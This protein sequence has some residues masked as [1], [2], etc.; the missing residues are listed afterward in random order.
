M[1]RIGWGD[2]HVHEKWKMLRIG[3]GDVHVHEKWKMLR[4]L[5]GDVHVHEKW[6][7][8]RIGWGD[9]HVHE[10]WKMLRI[11]WG[12]VHVHEKWKMLRIRWGDVHVHEK[13]K[14]LRI[15]WGDV[16]VHEKWK[17]LRIGWG[18][19]HVHEKWKMLRIGWGDVHVHEKWKML[20]ILWGDVH[21][22]E[23][24]KMLRIGWGDVHVHEKWKM[25]RIG[26]GDTFFHE[27]WKPLQMGWGDVLMR[28]GR[29]YRNHRQLLEIMQKIFQVVCTVDIPSSGSIV[30][31]G[32]GAWYMEMLMSGDLTAKTAQKLRRWENRHGAVEKMDMGFRLVTN[33]SIWFLWKLPCR[34]SGK[35]A[36]CIF[37]LQMKHGNI[38][39]EM[40]VVA[41]PR[42][43]QRQCDSV[44]WTIMKTLGRFF[45]PF[46]SLCMHYFTQ[47]C[48]D[49]YVIRRHGVYIT[50]VSIYL[51]I[52]IY[53][54][55]K[56]CINMYTNYVDWYF[57]LCFLYLQLFYLS[58][59]T[60]PPSSISRPS[61]L[62]NVVSG[63]QL[64]CELGNAAGF[65][66][67]QRVLEFPGVWN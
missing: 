64:M 58:F 53:I 44:I 50:Y 39:A 66:R 23:K 31:H 30:K 36:F 18:D 17:M 7:M 13:W 5:W 49:T 22:H 12:D 40:K 43:Q 38:I 51:N 33:W 15:G 46:G 29:C 41:K 14:M 45:G 48:L 20:R 42:F 8:L 67:V 21:V 4:V 25:L 32:I 1:L 61:L 35:A 52:Y 57:Q 37:A 60:P 34:C 2:V 62:W 6:K 3:W 28:N 19:V 63:V 65:R 10:K 24:W 47:V 54:Y 11:G 9:V 16:H 26:W 56:Q 27:K 55:V 59:I